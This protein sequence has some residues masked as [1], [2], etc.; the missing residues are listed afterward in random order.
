MERD[1]FLMGFFLPRAVKLMFEIWFP[2]VIQLFS[3]CSPEVPLVDRSV[4]SGISR[5]SEVLAA[6]KPPPRKHNQ[7][8]GSRPM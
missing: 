6:N 2:A 3:C 5:L 4:A 7:S 1:A 8:A